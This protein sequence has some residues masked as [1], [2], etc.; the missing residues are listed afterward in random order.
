MGFRGIRLTLERREMFM[1]QL[2]AIYRASA[3]GNV[4]IL[5]P[6]VIS[7]EEIQSAKKLTE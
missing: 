2:R 7:V 1:T 3:Y 6:L 5:Y 4:S